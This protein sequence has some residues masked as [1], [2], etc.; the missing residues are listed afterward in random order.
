[1]SAIN[2]KMRRSSA[3]RSG[4]RQKYRRDSNSLWRIKTPERT[5]SYNCAV[6]KNRRESPCA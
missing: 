6:E 1:M 5:F 4:V 3:A 2:P